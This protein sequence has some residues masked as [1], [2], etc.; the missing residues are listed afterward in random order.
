MNEDI[1]HNSHSSGLRKSFKITGNLSN[2]INRLITK[3]S[4]SFLYT[5]R[6]A[7]TLCLIS[8]QFYLKHSFQK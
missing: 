5:L 1:S 2:P 7:S 4:T 3:I 8:L 6:R